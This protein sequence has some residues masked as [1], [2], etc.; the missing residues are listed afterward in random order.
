MELT[1]RISGISTSP[2]AR[3]SLTPSAASAKAIANLR[4]ITRPSAVASSGVSIFSRGLFLDPDGTRTRSL[5][6]ILAS[7]RA[8]IRE[9][10]TKGGKTGTRVA[11][12]V[13]LSLPNEFDEEASGHAVQ[14]ILRRLAS[15]SQ[16]VKAIGVLHHDRPGNKHAHLLL[17]DGAETEEQARKRRPDAKRVRRQDVLRFGDM[18]RPKEVRALIAQAIRDTAQEFGISCSVEHLSFE[19]RGLTHPTK[20]HGTRPGPAA[21]VKAQNRIRLQA[22][23]HERA[24]ADAEGGRTPPQAVAKAESERAKPQASAPRAICL[25]LP[26]PTPH[27]L[28]RKKRRDLCR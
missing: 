10:S 7:M 6:G 15:G 22:R 26:A 9:R 20:H 1:T 25:P 18:G 21:L 28:K 8:A 24:G 13:I 23:Q 19:D 17:L 3:D 12:K 2:A 16:E 5:S 27:P 11:E 14:L 4:Y